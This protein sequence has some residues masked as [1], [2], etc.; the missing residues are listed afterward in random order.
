[1]QCYLKD[2]E[3]REE[4]DE[5]I[6][7]CISEIKNL[8]FDVEDCVESFSLKETLRRQQVNGVSLT[9]INPIKVR[10]FVSEVE[11]IQ[12]RISS[13][14][15]K[16][17]EYGV[18]KSSKSNT[19]CNK[20]KGRKLRRT[21]LHVTE[22][23]VVRLEKDTEKLM[24]KLLDEDSCCRVVSIYGMGGLGKTTLAKK[25]YHH[26]QVRN[27]FSCFVWVYVSQEWKTRDVW[28]RI[29]FRIISN[30][31]RNE[32]SKLDDDEIAKMLYQIQQT[33]KC[34]I[35]LDDIWCVDA[36]KSL[37]AG[38]PLQDSGSKILLTTRVKEVA[39]CVDPRGFVHEPRCLCFKESWELFVKI[40]SR[41]DQ[42]GNI[43]LTLL[44]FLY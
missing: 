3:A 19:S 30:K 16:L 43:S 37:S 26:P 5:R 27:H 17:E 14:M 21:Y 22:P 11:A 33:N 6:R 9:S 40:V 36:W 4:T 15:K 24:A 1:M 41:K 12:V 7:R 31:K 38:F 32:I 44:C 10:K 2:A 25:V 20:N 29:L 39:A 8:A 42:T 18:R 28:E 13:L 34:L 35:V 23:N